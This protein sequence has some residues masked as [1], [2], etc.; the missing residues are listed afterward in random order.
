M[1]AWFAAVARR[2]TD[3]VREAAALPGTE[4]GL[5]FRS[6]HRVRMA[7]RGAEPEDVRRESRLYC[8]VGGD[9]LVKYYA[10]SNAAF[11]VGD[12]IE[13]FIRDGPWPGR[14]AGGIAMR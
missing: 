3:R 1:K 11:D 6:V 8:H 5:R 13:A 4:P 7:I 10:S 9:W 14:G 12:A 2:G